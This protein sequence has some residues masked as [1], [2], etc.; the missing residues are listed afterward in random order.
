MKTQFSNPHS[1]IL[2]SELRTFILLILILFSFDQNSYSQPCDFYNPCR[3]LSGPVFPD[4]STLCE[5]ITGFSPDYTIANGAYSSGLHVTT[6]DASTTAF[7]GKDILIQGIFYIDQP[8]AFISCR[9]KL[10]AGAQIIVQT[11]L[12]KNE[13]LAFHC[14]FFSCDDMW[15]GIV[16]QYNTRCRLFSNRIEDAQFALTVD[17]YVYTALYG[18]TTETLYLS[19]MLRIIILYHLYSSKTTPL[20]VQVL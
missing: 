20:I 18:N 8:T 3:E 12:T 9:I 7:N 15:K 19:R 16:L 13:L 4:Q 1:F 14:K 11:K 17:S 5:Q 6:W 10:A 2:H